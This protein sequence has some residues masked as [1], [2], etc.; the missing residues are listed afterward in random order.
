MSLRTKTMIPQ[1]GC[2]CP[3][4]PTIYINAAAGDSVCTRCGSV[5]SENALVSEVTFGETSG[6]AAMAHGTLVAEGSS[7]FS[8][9]DQALRFL[10]VH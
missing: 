3:G 6:G 10:T 4:A 2:Q 1:D 5:I 8:V 7:T 9:Q